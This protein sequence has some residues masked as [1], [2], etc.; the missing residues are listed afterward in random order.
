M[1]VFRPV[2]RRDRIDPVW[3]AALVLIV[4]A[5]LVSHWRLPE[6]SGIN[7]VTGMLLVG[8]FNY[9]ALVFWPNWYTV[10]WWNVWNLLI[11]IAAKQ[12]ER[13]QTMA[14]PSRT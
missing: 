10:G 8:V 6:F 11:V 3:G 14:E 12:E 1:H 2:V 7:V 13:K 9:L 5:A 4:A